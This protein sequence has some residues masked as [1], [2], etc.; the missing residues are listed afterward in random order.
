MQNEFEASMRVTSM[1]FLKTSAAK[2]TYGSTM[3]DLQSEDFMLNS[4]Q[5][6]WG[7]HFNTNEKVDDEIGYADQQILTGGSLSILRRKVSQRPDKRQEKH[8]F[9]LL[10]GSIT[11]LL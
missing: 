6:A 2:S 4:Q 8:N 7:E 1:S 3:Q 9:E 11:S 10:S 5:T